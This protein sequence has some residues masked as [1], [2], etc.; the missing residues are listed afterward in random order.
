MLHDDGYTTIARDF[1]QQGTSL[2]HREVGPGLPLIYAPALLLPD[3]FQAIGRYFTT[4]LLNILSF[5]LMFLLMRKLNLSEMLFGIAAMFMIVHPVFIHWTIK[6]APEPLVTLLLLLFAYLILCGKRFWPGAAAI[7]ITSIFVRPTFLFIPLAMLALA[8]ADKHKMLVFFSALLIVLS[9]FGYWLNNKITVQSCMDDLTT[10]SS[11]L[12][13]II[14][15]AYFVDNVLQTRRFTTGSR[16]WP[17]GNRPMAHQQYWQW[18]RA[19]REPNDNRFSLIWKFVEQHPRM[20][21][22]KALFNPLFFLSMCSSTTETWLTLVCNLVLLSFGIVGIFSTGL[23]A[24]QK[25]LLTIA[26]GYF[27]IFWIGHAYSRYIYAL[28]PF[29]AMFAAQG[30]LLLARYLD[31]KRNRGLNNLHQP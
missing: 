18:L 25:L 26:L 23:S 22:Q 16:N 10:Y 2:F 29:L 7:F 14:M 8:L 27:F 24:D 11:G 19:N 1:V 4:V 6:S 5:I 30:V 13:E 21:L 31:A 20:I 3:K 15:D 12:H 9:I 17:D 28:L